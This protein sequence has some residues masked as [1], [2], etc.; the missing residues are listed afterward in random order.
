MSVSALVQSP[1]VL[2][3][4]NFS[5]DAT[6]N[7]ASSFSQVNSKNVSKKPRNVKTIVLMVVFAIVIVCMIGGLAAALILLNPDRIDSNDDATNHATTDTTHPQ[8]S[9]PEDSGVSNDTY[10]SF[11][12]PTESTPQ[13]RID[14]PDRTMFT[15]YPLPDTFTVDN[16][17]TIEFSQELPLEGPARLVFTH[18]VSPNH[19]TRRALNYH[20][21]PSNNSLNTR[22]V[23]EP[24]IDILMDGSDLTIRV[25]NNMGVLLQADTIS[26]ILPDAGGVYITVNINDDLIT[27]GVSGVDSFEYEENWTDNVISYEE[28]TAPLT[29]WNPSKTY[30]VINSVL[31][32]DDR[33][34][35]TRDMAAFYLK[36]ETTNNSIYNDN[37]DVK[38]NYTPYIRFGTLYAGSIVPSSAYDQ[39]PITEN[40]L[41]MASEDALLVML[42]TPFVPNVNSD[43]IQVTL[44]GSM[45]SG[46]FDLALFNMANDVPNLN[47]DLAVATWS[48]KAQG[49]MYV[50]R[51]YIGNSTL[52]DTIHLLPIMSYNMANKYTYTLNL[53]T[54]LV[55]YTKGT[56][57]P[58][59]S[60]GNLVSGLLSPGHYFILRAGPS[61]SNQTFSG[62]IQE[63]H[64]KKTRV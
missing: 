59:K 10:L 23:S 64:I 18:D 6:K 63:I 19:V 27:V 13:Y 44:T 22:G 29:V 4:D 61:M 11:I 45:I 39:L 5:I 26:G 24:V 33:Q 46:P 14:D 30:A 25:A 38:Y 3:D 41:R 34:T 8:I 32:Y 50:A 37:M 35:T 57:N 7:I 1:L 42:Q 48:F 51:S 31:Y 47:I 62:F 12:L 21:D 40:G 58:S 36:I 43:V 2:Y 9:T 49:T 16:N 56:A 55:E 60:K 20:L 53:Q 28:Y 15:L 52:E 54:K 17:I